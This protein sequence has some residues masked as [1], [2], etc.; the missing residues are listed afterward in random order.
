MSINR[1]LI[2][3]IPLLNDHD[4]TQ[5]DEGNPLILTQQ[6]SIDNKTKASQQRTPR[7][8]RMVTCG[9]CKALNQTHQQRDKQK[10]DAH[11]LAK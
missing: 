5:Q 8:A 1:E 11:L 10:L 3:D 2:V 4:V 9:Y 7:T 6:T